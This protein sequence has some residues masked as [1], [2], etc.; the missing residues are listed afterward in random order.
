M[1]AYAAA[2][3]S[4]QANRL[5]RFLTSGAEESRRAQNYPIS[6]W[7]LRPLAAL[8]ARRLEYSTV[9][10]WQV[11]V[12]GFGLTLLAALSITLLSAPSVIAC[13]LILGAWFC[14]R[15]DGQLA[16]RQGA[17]SAFGAWL[18]ANLDELADLTL[19]TSFAYASAAQLGNVAWY[20]WGAF[21]TGKYLFMY[22]LA[23][24]EDA[25]EPT[26]SPEAQQEAGLAHRL[27]H[28][29]ANADVRVHLAAAAA[30]CGGL[31]FELAFVAAYY[32]FRWM[33]RYILV[34]RRLRE[35]AL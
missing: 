9:R 21:V 27:Y 22:G 35:G 4:S 28:L 14:D 24:E 2:T 6:R 16:R 29:P 32:Q 18:D 23:A 11:T 26:K 3:S 8:V 25:V 13:L 20:L 19:Q 17:A 15:L 12:A 30:F 31:G 1:G 10:P 34:A 7:Y 33:A 5:P